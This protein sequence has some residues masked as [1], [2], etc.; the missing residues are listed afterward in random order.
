MRSVSRFLKGLG[1][2][3]LVLIIALALPWAIWFKEN[4]YID[5][6]QRL[7]ILIFLTVILALQ[8]IYLV[9]PKPTSRSVVDDRKAVVENYLK[10]FLNKYY[11]RLKS[12]S[13][14]KI[15]YEPPIVRVNV[16]LPTKRANGLFRAYLKIYYSACPEGAP[17]DG[18]VRSTKWGK[19]QGVCGLAWKHGDWTIYDSE[20][21]E[22]KRA[23]DRMKRM[24]KDQDSVVDKTKSVFSYPL[25]Y[26]DN[27]VG[28]FNLES[29]EN[30]DRTKFTD[31]EV[32]I[33]VDRC[34]IEVGGLC[35]HQDGVKA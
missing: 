32:G 15:D 27:V 29:L 1:S 23:R 6:N 16:M 30:V 24:S 13:C 31:D 28:I 21:P 34:V 8:Q 11:D 17:Y 26:H 25:R 2:V 20:H 35:Y 12:F 7:L 10:G 33:L 4:E 3:V 19:G 18:V 9:L 22:L 5:N 14:N